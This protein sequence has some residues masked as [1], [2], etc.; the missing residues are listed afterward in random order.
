[1]S[2]ALFIKGFIIGLSLAIP[3]GPIGLLCIRRTLA[4]GLAA[5][6]CSGFGA[7]TADGVYGAIAGFGLTFVSSFLVSHQLLLR[8]VGGAFLC[9]LGARIYRSV[10]TEKNGGPQVQGHFRDYVSTLFLTFTNPVTILAFAAAFATLGMAEVHG[11]YAQ[12][13]ALILGV[14]SGSFLWWIILS[15]SASIFHERINPAGLRFVNKVSGAVIAIFGI[16]VLLS[17][18]ATMTVTPLDSQRL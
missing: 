7:A 14:F 18:V 11:E 4:R 15:G 3:L 2:L 5:G 13:T 10:P 16:I 17:V 9:Y 6:L 8:L 1:M 12:P